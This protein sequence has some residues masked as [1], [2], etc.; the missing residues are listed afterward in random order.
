MDRVVEYRRLTGKNMSET[1][2]NFTQ[3]Q[4]FQPLIRFSL[5]IIL[6]LFLQSLYGAVDLM[7]VGQFAQNAD[8]SAVSTG[9]QVMSLVTNFINGLSMGTS[10]LLGQLIGQQKPR[11]AGRIMGA[12][13]FF[14]A[15]LGIVF[16]VIMMFTN[17]QLAS[18]MNAPA[19]ALTATRQYLFI[20]SA[21]LIF[22]SAYNLLSSLF[23]GIGNSRLPLI[24]VAIAAVINIFGDLL[25][26]KGFHMGAA[27]AAYATV[28]SQAISVLLSLLIARRTK[29]PF[30]ME[31]KDL[32]WN[33]EAVRQ[34]L[35]YGVPIALGDLLVGISFLIILSIVNSLGLLV[36]AGVGVAEK[37]CGFIMLVPAAFSQSLAAFVAQ[38]YGAQKLDRAHK[39]MHYAI[40]SSVTMG[41]VLS[42]LSFFHGDLLCGIFSRDAEV[43][44]AGWEYLRAYSIDVL[45]TSVFFCYNGYFNGCGYTRFVM[46][47]A[48]VG[49]FGVRIPVSWAMS[50]RTPVSIFHIGLATPCSSLIQT[51]LCLLY[52]HTAVRKKEQALQRA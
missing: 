18:L 31:R 24:S 15:F 42:W 13:I 4:I 10:I 12:S 29:L 37:V 50:R 34:V 22:I 28:A 3:G 7:V 49:A 16:S 51:I 43:I 23:R 20:C 21:G 27:G 39:G 46:A 48:V 19:E 45:L 14:F 41:A 38:N 17:A 8:V 25:L 6:A 1:N 52:M 5:P 33:R 35:H 9:A 44:Q 47:E 36:S 32:R 2:S 11:E 40:L 26:V 30:T